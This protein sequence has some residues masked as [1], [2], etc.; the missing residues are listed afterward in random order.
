M[1]MKINCSVGLVLLM[2][3]SGC[4]E[5]TSSDVGKE[6]APEVEA[7][8]VF[9]DSGVKVIDRD[10]RQQVS[11]AVKNKGSEMAHVR[12]SAVGDGELLAGFA[13][14][15]SVAWETDGV[16]LGIPPGEVWEVPMLLH[17]DRAKPGKY[18]VKMNVLDFDD[19]NRVISTARQEVEV[20][21]P[22]VK[23][24][25][26]VV[27]ANDEIGAARLGH[28]LRIKNEGPVVSDLSVRFEQEGKVAD[29]LLLWETVV[30][31]YRLK[32]RGFIEVEFAP[33]LHPNF[34]ELKGDLVISGGTKKE[35]VPFVAAIPEGKSVYVTLSRTT[36]RTDATGRRC[37]NRPSVNYS[38]PATEGSPGYSGGGPRYSGGRGF[39][40]G[41]TPDG[42]EGEPADEEEEDDGFGWLGGEVP[43]SL[44]NEGEDDSAADQDGAED[45]DEG[46]P[47]AEADEDE[48]LFDNLDAMTMDVE[49]G[50]V[51]PASN[52]SGRLYDDMVKGLSEEFE[53]GRAKTD[54]EKPLQL[55]RAATKA[56]YSLVMENGEPTHMVHRRGKKKDSLNFSFGMQSG[57]RKQVPMALGYR[58]GSPVLGPAPGGGA[59]ATYVRE[60][61][62]GGEVIEML[63][64]KSGKK[65]TF[66]DP[67]KKSDSPRSVMAGD[68]VD[69]YFREDGKLKKARVGKGMEEKVSGGTWPD[70]VGDVG[71][72]LKAV[73]MPDGKDL[74]ATRE[75][76]GRVKLRSEAG[77]EDVAGTDVDIAYAG[78]ER[79]MAVRRENGA[80]DAMSPDGVK[81]L[82]A[83]SPANSAPALVKTSDGGMRMYFNRGIPVEPPSD[84][85]TGVE[86]GGNFSMDYK[87]GEWEEPRRQLLPEAPVEEAAVVTSFEVP[88]GKAH[89]K[90]MDVNISVNGK[91]AGKIEGKL[92][93]GRFIHRINP[94]SLN[95]KGGQGGKGNDIRIDTKGMSPGHYHYT[96]KASLYTGHRFCQDCLVAGSADEAEKLASKSDQA[97]RH[98]A[99]DLI[100]ASN[101]YELPEN[102]KPGEEVDVDVSLFNTGDEPVPAGKVKTIVG[103]EL[104]GEADYPAVKAFRGHKAKMKVKLPLD[105]DTKKNLK[106]EV[107]AEVPGDV[108]PSTNRLNFFIL[109]KE[110]PELA[111]PGGPRNVDVAS[112]PKD[113]IT[114]VK[115][116]GGVPA[117]LP[118]T[119]GLQWYG[120]PVKKGR[121]EVEVKGPEAGSV[122]DL[123]LFQADGQPYDPGRSTIKG[124]LLYLRLKN[125]NSVSEKT[126]MKLWW[127]ENQG[128]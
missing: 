8:V 85:V 127:S 12:L 1:K 121:L 65:V 118:L 56:S 92:P 22:E 40:G 11:V 64:P 81:A 99:P 84:G 104:V 19:G 80:I 78:G 97:V 94:A 24:W 53:K 61:G 13:G 89:Y 50:H 7:T 17:A 42:I 37:T 95:F 26:S 5:S 124:D 93:N 25:V 116:E 55:M 49:E 41:G 102:A 113:Q 115:L 72:V 108:D 34:K 10:Y 63:D 73:K 122:T 3:L 126:R 47:A 110:N 71:P 6:R 51:P 105:W 16:A 106:M 54:L 28:V 38:M 60:S 15:G 67:K 59:A 29:D 70:G 125:Q 82:V 86:L 79:M 46:G 114:V 31:E 2:G 39:Q 107:S 21:A 69:V 45:G 62:E 117:E 111:G 100:V 109:R 96:D 76:G 66:G 119:K 23:W 88:F 98:S 32:E 101:G 91:S 57:K 77:V 35:R 68:D 83:A 4:R 44:A 128:R 14:R 58:A 48:A 18:E 120:V 33:R 103:G 9:V 123:K 87:D 20:R 30:E 112:I 36:R 75:V 74:V 52:G 27:P 90:K 43:D